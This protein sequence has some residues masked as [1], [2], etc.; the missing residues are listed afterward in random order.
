M[1]PAR[2]LPIFALSM[3][4]L[5]A[6]A[7]ADPVLP[8]GGRL[9]AGQALI[10]SPAGSSLTIDQAS[11]RAIINWSSFSI[12]AG[13][14][15]QF[16]NGAGA[17]LNRVMG[18][19]PSQLDGFLTAT[20]SVFLLNPDGVIVGKGGVINVGGTF[21]ASTLDVADD[22]FMKGGDLTFSGASQAA[23]INAG[24]ITAQAGD[25]ALIGLS[26]ENDG[27]I[28]APGGDAALGAGRVVLL[29][30]AD[31]GEGKLAV[32][33]G[34]SDTS[35]TNAGLIA[36][37]DAELRANGGNVYALAVNPGAKI[38][39][40]GVSV[41]DGKVYLI[42][43]GGTAVAHGEIDAPGGFVETS[44]ASVDFTGLKVVA[45]NWLIDP[46]TLTVDQ[47]AADTISA[48][49]ATAGVTLQTTSSSASSTPSGIGVQSSGAGDIIINAP[50]S[51]ST[52]NTLSLDAY[53]GIQINAPIVAS[54]AGKVTLATNDGGVGGLLTFEPGASLSFTGAPKI[55][56]AL[57]L[58]GQ[59]YTLIYTELQLLHISADLA[60]NYALARPLI[61]TGSYSTA[62]VA[63]SAAHPFTGSFTGLGNTIS[64]LNIT[65]E[66]SSIQLLGYGYVTR[67]VL[68]L[69]GFV[70]SGGQVSNVNLANASVNGLDGMDVGALVG[71][72]SGTVNN[73]SSTGTIS[74][75]GGFSAQSSEFAAAGGLV[76]VS[77][78]SIVNSSSSADVSG[79]SA[80]AGGL[81]GQAGPGASVIGS[82]A[83]GGVS[84]GNFNGSD[85]PSA[86]GGLIGVV[87]G[88]RIDGGVPIPVE[89]SYSYATGAVSGGDTSSVGGFVGSVFQ[90]SILG[91]YATGAVTT[92][93]DGYVS[94]IAGG[95][96]GKLGRGA[97][98]TRS[99]SQGSVSA[100]A[101]LPIS[102]F[103]PLGGSVT[104]AGGF[105]GVV[106]DS[107]TISQAYSQTPVAIT[108]SGDS[109]VGGFAGLEEQGASIDH[110]Y[111]AGQ[112]TAGSGVQADVGGLVG[113]LGNP[114][115]SGPEPSLSDSY[116]DQ[117]ATGQT[118]AFVQL[119]S[120]TVS[121]VVGMSSSGPSP[122][123][124]ATYVGWD[125]DNTWSP[126]SDPVQA[127][128]Y[129]ELYG[130]S[131]VLRVTTE[132]VSSVY[133][134]SPTF[135][136]DY[137]GFQYGDGQSVVT[138]GSVSPQGAG[139]SGAGFYN[140]GAYPLL[141]SGFSA[142]DP[143][144]DYRII[145]AAPGTL[146]ITPLT[147]SASLTGTVEKTYDGT[148][149]ASLGA[150]NFILVGVLENDI[151]TATGSGSYDNKDAG[152][153]KL[154]S[155]GSVAFS[156]ADGGNYQLEGLPDPA[157][158]GTIDPAA[159]TVTLTGTVEKTYDGLPAATLT[160]GNY[161]LSGT[162]FE[163]DQVS[164]NGPAA[165]TYDNKN[166]GSGKTVS[167]SGLSLGGAS[168]GDYALSSASVSGAVGIIDPASLVISAMSDARTYDSTTNSA[169]APQ[170][171]G[172]VEG[173]NVSSLSQS[174]DSKHVGDRT[175]SVN[176]GFVVDDGNGGHNYAVTLH[177]ASGS[178][179][180]ALLTVSLTGK[181]EK[182]YDG[183]TGAT[184]TSANYDLSGVFEGDTVSLNGGAAGTYDTKSVGTG[185][186][187][188]V[189]GL[190]LGGASAGDYSVNASVSGAVG[191]IDPKAL[192]A[193]LIGVVQKTHDGST[194]A[195]LGAGNYQLVGVVSGDA[196]SL[197]DPVNG[198]YDT[199]SVGTGKQVTVTGL[200]LTGADAG[201]YTVNAIADADIGVIT[202][203]LPFVPPIQVQIVVNSPGEDLFRFEDFDNSPGGAFGTV[204]PSAGDDGTQTPTDNL[205][206]TGAGNGDLWTGS[207]L[208]KGKQP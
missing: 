141:A 61:L 74:T 60:G 75:G 10:G 133:G 117:D 185:K 172:L 98:V 170:V 33:V 27:Q 3:L 95:F 146:A 90:G 135:P 112:V 47:A 191:I 48:D 202:G 18:A 92:G 192:T 41:G 19:A 56:Q 156:G 107:A 175:L 204:F 78:G 73:A 67:G 184:L 5:A 116:W 160:S 80:S 143:S 57:T 7:K 105:V 127:S 109:A 1:S 20:G 149:S 174:F 193:E 140:A 168:A 76:G 91:A 153:H 72:L 69:F 201:D 115:G 130:V 167:V 38:E 164:L 134:Q 152:T 163:G 87:N 121:Q 50:I 147:I 53:H 205:A 63:P 88:A 158:I 17:T 188:S 106:T 208:D 200:A 124:P 2:A 176:D 195:T 42:A 138:V 9:I 155:V 169:K 177:T 171:S 52:G 199:Q 84:A 137:Y 108:G 131:H 173:D 37:A 136:V 157:D 13:G 64:D 197:N 30:A 71:A 40:T 43:E 111:A 165:G 104:Y 148:P 36:A 65:A 49:L 151:V 77:F 142:T 6:G 129:P 118:E 203:V 44:G 45:A 28:K 54:G 14:K 99:F 79:G 189:S 85:W 22:A 145:Y 178:I 96:A 132:S 97:S 196:V 110:V 182:T 89:V 207:D 11:G 144:G 101:N 34:G 51:W 4:A 194:Q 125:F 68:G 119:T 179:T 59:A 102:D 58:N 180:A 126:P 120:P 86:A 162:I 114:T 62:L 123:D 23:V 198:A 31:D 94:A 100:Q 103:A 186:T 161:S 39:A 32:I 46:V 190:S 70:G 16:N 35:A 21:V 187:V 183:G 81:L 24:S 29:R 15:V 25:A 128:Y 122:F 113:D 181:V 66:T 82:F 55:G 159:L 93:G 8:T 150:S 154:V 206:V 12:G 83:S 139:L 26:V 166:A